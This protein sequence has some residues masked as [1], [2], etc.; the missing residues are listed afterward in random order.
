MAKNNVV[1]RDV[2]EQFVAFAE[3][4]DYS[5]I[6]TKLP[7]FNRQNKTKYA[8]NTMLVA[9]SEHICPVTLPHDGE[10]DEGDDDS[11]EVVDDMPVS[12]P[13]EQSKDEVSQDV[14]LVAGDFNFSD[15][16]FEFI[17]AQINA[18]SQYDTDLK[19]ANDLADQAHYIKNVEVKEINRQIST[20]QKEISLAN[21]ALKENNAKY[22]RLVIEKY[23]AFITAIP[24]GKAMD[25]ALCNLGQLDDFQARKA[26]EA[27]TYVWDQF[28]NHSK[29]L[30]QHRLDILGTESHL[31]EL[32][33]SLNQ[34]FE[35]NNDAITRMYDL[36]RQ[37]NEIRRKYGK[38]NLWNK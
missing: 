13:E 14:P 22:R 15:L 9:I 29:D 34:I 7:E 23:E 35:K 17:N 33:N 8:L 36:G 37:A 27:A 19:H 28:W 11:T 3:S 24:V 6:L 4:V 26:I 38:S 20:V 30:E 32:D 16:D 10:P 1:T 21:A 5:A 12:Q 25:A 2:A 31:V 18:V